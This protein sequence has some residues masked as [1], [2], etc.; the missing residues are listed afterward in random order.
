MKKMQ[1]IRGILCALICLG[2]FLAGCSGE[3]TVQTPSAP[4][5]PPATKAEQMLAAMDKGDQLLMQ[6]EDT[7]GA[8]VFSF[9]ETVSGNGTSHETVT[10]HRF[11]SLGMSF[12]GNSAMRLERQTAY[13]DGV[14]HTAGTFS[15]GG[16]EI[17]FEA[18]AHK[19]G[20]FISLPQIQDG[21]FS[22]TPPAAASLPNQATERLLTVF[23]SLLTEDLVTV[24]H[25]D[26][27]TEY[28]AVL[29]E[30]A[31]TRLKQAMDE[32][33]VT[34]LLGLEELLSTDGAQNGTTFL[35]VAV[36]ASETLF[37]QK[38][39]LQTGDQNLLQTAYTLQKAEDTLSL[40]L[41]V[42]CGGSTLLQWDGSFA[43]Q[44]GRMDARCHTAFGETALDTELT[45]TADGEKNVSATGT[46][47]VTLDYRG[48]TA[49]IPL[50]VTGEAALGSD[51]VRTSLSV[52]ASVS[53]MLE[54]FLEYRGDFTPGT[55]A[56]PEVFAG[57]DLTEV[58]PDGLVDSLRDTYPNAADLYDAL[59]SKE[60]PPME[61]V[62][63]VTYQDEEGSLV[64]ASYSDGTVGL[65][66][67][68]DFSMAEGVLSLSYRGNRLFAV[69]YVANEN[70]TFTIWDTTFTYYA[71]STMDTYA[72]V[73]PDGSSW[74]ELM[75]ILSANGLALFDL[76]LPAQITETALELQMPDGS[77]LSIPYRTADDDLTAL[78][79][80]I[81]LKYATGE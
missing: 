8:P 29:G 68:G 78:L 24:T 53:G 71:D 65:S 39:V 38:T 61:D 13:L 3:G 28:T 40:E 58:D 70:N 10:L 80:D 55:P 56:I 52:S 9:L 79:W 37:S 81:P 35:T 50:D 36:F 21:N 30:A 12:V 43:A 49:S 63:S 77:T 14:T 59:F 16:D 67:Q 33:G 7:F 76:C 34:Q 4:T 51:T 54:L 44:K 26:G 31:W 60:E 48:A 17:P 20:Q 45:L 66:L 42:L 25:K 22:L 32:S 18:I 72:Y 6:A 57:K 5:A 69:P 15:A 73:S 2:I 41:S 74:I 75:P 62:T 27:G 46:T 23:R 47:T 64:L 19:D 11:S 1:V